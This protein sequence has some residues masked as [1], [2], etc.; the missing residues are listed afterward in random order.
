MPKVA[1]IDDNESLRATITTVLLA[2]D[3][4]ATAFE[5]A[6]HFLNSARTEDF[7]VMLVDK[8]MPGM[9]GKELFDLMRSQNNKFPKFILMS[10]SFSNEDLASTHMS[11]DPI[12]LA[13]PFRLNKL[14]MLLATTHENS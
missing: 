11:Q 1:I 13:K 9:T 6:L 7:E 5:S 4:D 12:L 14:L 10:G 3:I 2:S 8:D